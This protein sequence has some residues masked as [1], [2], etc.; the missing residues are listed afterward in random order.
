M[1]LEQKR[2]EQELLDFEKNLF[3][4][5]AKKDSLDSIAKIQ[6]DTKTKVKKKRNR[7]SGSDSGEE[8]TKVKKTRRSS[9]SSAASTGTRVS[10]RRERH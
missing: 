5:Q 9:P 10:V 6:A 4:D 7:R 3:G 8:K 2:I 1:A